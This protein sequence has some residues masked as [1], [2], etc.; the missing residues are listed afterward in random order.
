MYKARLLKRSFILV[1]HFFPCMSLSFI[2]F[3]L[4]KEYAALEIFRFQEVR[5]HTES[6]QP[7]K[8]PNLILKCKASAMFFLE[9]RIHKI[10]R[11]YP[12]TFHQYFGCAS[13]VS[14]CVHTRVALECL[15][16]FLF[17]CFPLHFPF[18]FF[19]FGFWLGMFGG[20]Q[21]CI[22]NTSYSNNPLPRRTL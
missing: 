16:S 21:P 17:Y 14:F 6:I 22:G 19:L 18:S 3:P 10:F 4:I 15:F 5:L 8:Y 13:W 1:K 20:G 2:F 9:I 12:K 7:Q 11:S